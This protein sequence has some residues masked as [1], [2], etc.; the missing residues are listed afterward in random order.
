MKFWIMGALLNY[1]LTFEK[2]V[3][4]WNIGELLMGQPLVT[5]DL[6]LRLKKDWPKYI[7]INIGITKHPNVST[8]PIVIEKIET[9]FF[10]TMSMDKRTKELGKS[11]FPPTLLF[12]IFIIHVVLILNLICYQRVFLIFLSFSFPIL[13]SSL[14]DTSIGVP[15]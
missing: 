4:F 5:Q 10:W 7:S 3:N 11:P 15:Y 6:V 2:R 9:G 8:F 1:G 14:F 13:F 12:N